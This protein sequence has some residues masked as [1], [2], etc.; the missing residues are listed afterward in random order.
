MEKESGKRK[1]TQIALFI[2]GI[3]ILI[4]IISVVKIYSMK[5]ETS[6][7]IASIE[8]LTGKT[9]Q[10]MIEDKNKIEV[11]L[12]F[13]SDKE[14]KQVGEKLQQIEGVK[15]IQF[16][17]KEEALKEMKE[18]LGEKVLSGFE[19]NNLFPN[20]YILEIEQEKNRESIINT[21]EEI[22]NVKK[23]VQQDKSITSMLETAEKAEKIQMLEKIVY[24]LIGGLILAFTILLICY[25]KK[26]KH[27]NK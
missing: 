24:V 7:Q 9:L 19:E 15:I 2:M 4:G 3:L 18:K 17:S 25:C 1:V 10:E 26:E 16:K 6:K 11:F 22:A 20:S 5:Q 12:K 21:I 27:N 8:K 23:I 13:V 14:A